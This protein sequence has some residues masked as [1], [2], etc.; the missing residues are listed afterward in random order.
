MSLQQR[1]YMPSYGYEC[2]EC[3]SQDISQSIYDN[4][5]T[6]CPKCGNLDFRKTFGMIG[7]SF[8]GSGFY[9]TDSRRNS[10]EKQPGNK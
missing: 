4:T 7:V 6:S 8:K 3:G 5:L 2:K 10:N 1:K 9:S